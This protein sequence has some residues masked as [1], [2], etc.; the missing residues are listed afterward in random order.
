ML[1]VFFSSLFGLFFSFFGLFLEKVF[2]KGGGDR[3]GDCFVLFCVSV[4]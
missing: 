3:D 1:L 4:C 2:V